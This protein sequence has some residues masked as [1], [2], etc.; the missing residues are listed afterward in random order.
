MK[1]G[2]A[3]AAEDLVSTGAKIRGT[4]AES[5]VGC[6]KWWLPFVF[7]S[8]GAEA[9]IG[10]DGSAT[11]STGGGQDKPNATYFATWSAFSEGRLTIL[12]DKPKNIVYRSMGEHT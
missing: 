11:G 8:T 4:T 3:G 9:G 7:K 1:T 10:S 2:G 6:D 12:L 5:P